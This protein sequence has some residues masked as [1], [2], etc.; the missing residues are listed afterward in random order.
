[1]KSV[2]KLFAAAGLVLAFAFAPLSAGAQTPVLPELKP[3]SPASLALA[4]ELLTIK[5]AGDMY[6]N[7][8]PSIVERTKTTLMQSNLN[9]QKDLNEVAIVVAKN[10]AGRQSEIADTMAHIYANH[11]TEQELKDLVA[12][13]KSPLGQKLLRE[14]PA[15]IQDSILYMGQ[16]AQQFSEVVNGEFRA[17]MRKRGKQI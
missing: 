5:K 15:A 3:V 13:Y 8:V 7:A 11:F 6:A 4:K 9:Y 16:W 17:E 14:E 10:L 1:M 2:F 12:F